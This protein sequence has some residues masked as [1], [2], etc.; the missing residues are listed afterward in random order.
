[1][2]SEDELMQDEGD[3]VEE[4]GVYDAGGE[5]SLRRL[6]EFELSLP[7]AINHTSVSP[8]GRKMICVGDTNEIFL[9]SVNNNG[10]YTLVHTFKGSQDASFSSDWSGTSDKFA[11]GSQGEWFPGP[12]LPSKLFTANR[13]HNLTVIDG[14]LHVYDL[15]NLPPSETSSSRY[16][17]TRKLA[18]IASSQTRE[19]GAIRKVK[20]SPSRTNSELLAFT[21]VS[22]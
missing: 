7:T 1:M 8:D 18:T 9:Y 22:S 11:V 4:E 20:F 12:G 6:P 16:A 21:E 5:C 14:F 3:L 17:S 2:D 13:A 15:R 10:S 19:A